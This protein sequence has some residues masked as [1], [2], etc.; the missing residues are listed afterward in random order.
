MK[1]YPT[2]Q[3]VD[4]SESM[5]YALSIATSAVDPAHQAIVQ[6]SDQ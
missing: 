2:K 5:L 3:W 4:L 6:L 1:M